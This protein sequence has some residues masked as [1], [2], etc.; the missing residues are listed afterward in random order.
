MTATDSAENAGRS[1]LVWG[2]TVGFGLGAIVDVIVFHLIFQHHHLLSNVYDPHTEEGFRMNVTVDGLFLG[3]MSLVIAVGV[4]MLWR[5]LNASSHRFSPR[6]TAGAL[7]VGA[8]VFNTVD[9]VVSHYILDIHDVVH[10]S[11]V[12]NPP[13][14]VVSLVLLAVGMVVLAWSEPVVGDLERE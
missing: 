4:V 10:G 5:T 3:V 11:T 7:L 9:G 6:F 8:G 1:L 2:G 14:V 12:W 13:W